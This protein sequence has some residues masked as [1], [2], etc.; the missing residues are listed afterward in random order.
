MYCMYIAIVHV[1]Y[2]K[3]LNVIVLCMLPW[4]T[5]LMYMCICTCCVALCWRAC[6]G[7][8]EYILPPCPFRA[9]NNVLIRRRYT[10]NCLNIFQCECRY[11]CQVKLAD[12][13]SVKQFEVLLQYC[14]EWL[15]Y[16]HMSPEECE[17]VMGTPGY[18]A[19]EVSGLVVE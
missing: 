13:D 6:R 17:K 1:H 14:Q 19:P 16:I 7:L 18:R 8:V 5:T 3:L 15:P 4:T 2:C 9:A 11:K 12:F 10:C